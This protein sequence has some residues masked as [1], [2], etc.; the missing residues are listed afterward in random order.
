MD[1]TACS[2]TGWRRRSASDDAEAGHGAQT[3]T[4]GHGAVSGM[5]MRFAVCRMVASIEDVW[6]FARGMAAA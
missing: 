6:R 5:S 1:A 4:A 2:V 3:Q